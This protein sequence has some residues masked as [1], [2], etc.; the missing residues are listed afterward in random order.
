MPAPFFGF[1]PALLRRSGCTELHCLPDAYVPVIKFKL[2]TISIDLIF[3]SLKARTTIPAN[4]DLLNEENLRGLD[5]E[6]V[7]R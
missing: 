6:S 3:A 7:R 4:L 1:L 2:K 5:Q